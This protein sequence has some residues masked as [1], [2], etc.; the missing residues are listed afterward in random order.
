MNKKITIIAGI[1]LI[2]FILLFGLI[3][4]YDQQKNEVDPWLTTQP[5]DSCNNFL[6][7]DRLYAICCVKNGKFYDCTDRNDF[8]PCQEIEILVN[9]AKVQDIPESFDYVCLVTDMSLKQANGLFR[10]VPDKCFFYN[11]DYFWGITGLTSCEE[12]GV[13]TLLKA[14][15]YP[16]GDKDVLVEKENGE[17]G[18]EFTILNIKGKI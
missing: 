18:N 17:I 8:K 10:S 11:K 1:S 15:L 12:E 9:P 16:N 6:H 14:N 2:I 3:T 5:E 4:Y 7:D 13:F